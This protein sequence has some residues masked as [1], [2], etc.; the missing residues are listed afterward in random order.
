MGTRG[1]GIGVWAVGFGFRG[2]G[3]A[4]RGF[5]LGIVVYSVVGFRDWGLGFSV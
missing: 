5:G 4:F 3:F 1:F 2:V